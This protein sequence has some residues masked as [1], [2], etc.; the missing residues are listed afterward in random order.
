MAFA[1]Y[2]DMEEHTDWSREDMRSAIDQILQGLV[3]LHEKQIVHR[4]I[5]PSTYLQ[6]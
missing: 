3:Y 4:D 2:R 5:K 1:K 6:F